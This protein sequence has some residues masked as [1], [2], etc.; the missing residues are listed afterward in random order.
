MKPLYLIGNWKN[1]GSCKAI[2]KFASEWPKFDAVG[3]VLAIAPPFP[4]LRMVAEALPGFILAAQDCS[5]AGV[6]PHTGDVA[7]EMLY[8]LKCQ[9]VILGHSERRSQHGEDDLKIAR[10]LIL[11]QRSGLTPVLCVGENA[12]ARD[13][14]KETEVVVQQLR[15]VI[16]GLDP[17]GLLIAYEP[18]WA[19]G[20]GQ[21]ATPEQGGRMH[22]IMR[23]ILHQEYRD[24][25]DEIPILYGGSVNANNASALFDCPDVDGALVGSASLTAAQFLGIAESALAMLENSHDH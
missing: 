11:A 22:A 3:L 23:D 8:D 16:S 1:H 12:V 25:A 24:H 20:T 19:I 4:Y 2:A 18:I 15:S 7:A 5:V 21:T 13:S 9:Y 10:K 17:V 14:G 6:G